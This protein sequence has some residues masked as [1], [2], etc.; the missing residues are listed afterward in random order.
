M[1]LQFIAAES[2]HGGKDR[3]RLEPDTRFSGRESNGTQSEDDLLKGSIERYGFLAFVAEEIFHRIFPAG[4][5]LIPVRK[6]PQTLWAFPRRLHS[7]S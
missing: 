1:G 3:S 6:M 4:M 5:L 2:V 7:V